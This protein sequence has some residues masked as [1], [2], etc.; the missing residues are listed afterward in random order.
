[1]VE[2]LTREFSQREEAARKQLTRERDAQLQ[3]LMQKLSEEHLQEQQ[4]RQRQLAQQQEERGRQQEQLLEQLELKA[5][6]LEGLKAKLAEANAG[7]ERAAAQASQAQGASALQQSE[8]EAYEAQMEAR[9][10]ALTLELARAQD[11]QHT[12]VVK[13]TEQEKLKRQQLHEEVR[14]L[15]DDLTE[16]RRDQASM[17]VE[18]RAELDRTIAEVEARVR[19]AIERKDEQIAALEGEIQTR[20]LKLVSFEKLLRRQREELL[21]PS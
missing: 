5:R 13:I 18:H 12:E 20:D 21:G 4:E 7:W 1:M 8:R 17:Q 9:V 3:E 11:S 19:R 10:R 2:K 15:T 6:E 14:R 16:M